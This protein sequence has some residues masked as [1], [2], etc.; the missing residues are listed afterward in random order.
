MTDT[1]SCQRCSVVRVNSL[2][3]VYDRAFAPES[4]DDHLYVRKLRQVIDLARARGYPEGRRILKPGLPDEVVRSLC[5]NI[6]SVL[7]DDD[8]IRLGIDIERR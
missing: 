5:W 6:S 4:T 2:C 7:T 3:R 8:L 1:K